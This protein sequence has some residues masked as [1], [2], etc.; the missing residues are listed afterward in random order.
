VGGD[1]T[2]VG[3]TQMHIEGPT[4]G[5]PAAAPS[6]PWSGWSWAGLV[7]AVLLEAA[8]ALAACLF[9][10]FGASTT[11]GQP[12]GRDEVVAGETGLLVAVA[13]GLAPWLL[14]LLAA[15][16]R[17]RLIVAGCLAVSPLLVALVAGLDPEFWVGSF[18][19]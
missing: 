10:S 18:C 17:V 13:I 14:S 12:A 4:S 3:M 11:C 5:W 16:H 6:R 8:L 19:F 7:A 9:I 2:V 1:G 15:R